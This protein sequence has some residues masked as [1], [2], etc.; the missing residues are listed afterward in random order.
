MTNK[1]IPYV[2]ILPSCI[3]LGG[4]MV[5]PLA[6]GFYLSFYD[7]LLGFPI[8][9][10][11]G[12]Q[13][14]LEL[15][16]LPTFWTYLWQSAVWTLGSLIGGTMLALSAALLMNTTGPEKRL[17]RSV[18]LTPWLSSS[19][20]IAL[21]W[22]WMFHGTFGIIN[23]LFAKLGLVNL[24]NTPLWLSDE[25]LAMPS[26]ILVNVWKGFPFGAIMYLA[27]L[28]GIPEELYEAGKI[29]GTNVWQRFIYITLPSIKAS[30]L[31]V[32]LFGTI[33]TFNY[34]DLI[35]LMTRGGPLD[36]T[37]ILATHLYKMAFTNY[38][39]GAACAIGTVMFV[40]MAVFSYFYIKL[41]K[42][43]D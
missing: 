24:V 19:V 30:M 34:F 13:N 32:I 5:Y 33:W 15:F 3:F 12:L 22:I 8:D 10:F 40:L 28:E 37:E 26:V 2:Y 16:R 23:D 21:V 1:R 4:V 35:W 27:A 41:Y 11:V 7:T 17:L 31:M 29:D 9:R 42:F 6:Y 36:H 18:I 14:Y 38:R 39:I 25:K 20:V 43:E